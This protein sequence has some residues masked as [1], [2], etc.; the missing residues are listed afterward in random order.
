MPENPTAT[1]SLSTSSSLLTRV[2]QN[3]PQAWE[4]LVDLYSPLVFRW[5]RWTKLPA[6]EAADVMQ[7]VFLAVFKNIARFDPEQPGA[8]FRGWL[9]TITR[10]AAN[11][12]I[13]ELVRQPQGVGGTTVYERLRELPVDLD[14]S[15]ELAPAAADV[16]RRAMELIQNEFETRTWRAAV[17]MIEGGS[18]SDVAQQLGMTPNAV[19]NAKWKVLRRLRDELGEP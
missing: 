13:G 5:C 4:R 18:A 19:R 14:E 17:L 11:D 1:G 6:Q 8:T 15:S 9:Y 7:N 3:E 12:R 16:V 10:N 2:R